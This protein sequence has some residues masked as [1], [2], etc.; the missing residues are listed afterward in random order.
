MPNKMITKFKWEKKAENPQE[1][2]LAI[3][4]HIKLVLKT[5]QFTNLNA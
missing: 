2:K 1:N 3:I 5:K 4:N